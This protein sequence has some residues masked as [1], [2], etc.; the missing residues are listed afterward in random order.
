MNMTLMHTITFYVLYGALSLT[1][2]VAIE[3]LIF[4]RVT[5]RQARLLE[6]T[7]TV[8]ALADPDLPAALTDN[9]TVP[10][11]TLRQMLKQRA[12]LRTRDDIEDLSG[13]IYIAMKARL[14]R[15][16]WVLDTIVTAAPLLGLLGTILGIIDTFTTLAQS[17][18]SDPQGVS[19]GIGTAL[20]ATALGIS[21]ALVG[22]LCLNHF[23][24]RVERISDHLKI[25][26]M[27]AA[28][29]LGPQEQAQTRSGPVLT[30]VP[31]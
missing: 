29:G 14:E 30:A 5:L 7:L 17:G 3:R 11:E 20:F 8:E 24:D 4:Y 21:V 26:L 2:F 19:A 18:I 1:V 9:D 31:A 28:M 16:L 25:L 12:L 6:S 22:L 15:H 10:T 23:R 27:R 13:A